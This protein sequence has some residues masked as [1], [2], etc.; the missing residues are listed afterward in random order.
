MTLHWLRRLLAALFV[1]TLTLGALAAPALAH[2]RDT[3]STNYISRVLEA[4]DLPGVQWEVY[5]GDQ[6]LAVTNTTDTELVVPGYEGEPY[7]RISAAGV[8]RNEAS[9]ATY[10]N[11]DRYAE[12]GELP[13]DV[14]ADQ[15]PRWVK[16]SDAATYA[17]HDHRTHW[18]GL[19][20][21]PVVVDPGKETLINPWQVP[22]SYGDEEHVIKGELRWVPPP[23]PVP[24]L[25][26]AALLTAP[27]L[28]GLRRREE[29]GWVPALVRPAA[30][31]LVVVS[32]LNLVHLVDDFF[33]VPLPI[34]S[35]LVT[36]VQT[37]LFIALGLFG[38]LV[39]WRG[40]DG[41]FTA[42]GVGSAGILIG[43]GV[44]YLE[45]LR[46]TSSASVFPSWVGR[47]VISLSLMQALWI[48]AVAI[49]GNRRLADRDEA[50]VV[51]QSAEVGA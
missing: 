35:H 50:V 26:V 22:F 25:A 46:S 11:D 36:A 39:A 41:A 19:T 8:H 34:T 14:G 17:W 4:P 13:P 40:R 6:F 49:I 47:L 33:A 7:L 10:E 31:V 28:L 37:A 29:E 3:E 5:G 9:K 43:Q 21:P 20:L 44:L 23:S 38:G 48:F 45:A 24:W 16:V 1:A 27:A 32:L 18:M 15:E 12:V 51:D 42:L 30:A 2:G